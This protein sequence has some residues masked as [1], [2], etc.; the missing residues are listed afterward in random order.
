MKSSKGKIQGALS[1]GRLPDEDEHTL[2]I[3]EQ[4]DGAVRFLC[5]SQYDETFT[6]NDGEIAT[7][8]VNIAED[9]E[10]GDYPIVIKDQKLTETDISHYYTMDFVQS[11]LT[12]VSYVL[13]DINSD[14]KVDV[15][16]YV[17]VANHIL[18]TAQ[19]GFNEKAGDVNEDGVIDVS[20]YVGV[21]NIILTGSIYGSNNAMTKVSANTTH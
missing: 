20:D 16:D 1:A 14:G 19:E 10:D 13:G 7:L 9:I 18:G 3:S 15:S 17:G 12:V 11:K 5:N 4:P 21:A 2:A 6:G 8:L